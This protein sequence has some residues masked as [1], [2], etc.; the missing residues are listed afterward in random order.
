MIEWLRQRQEIQKKGEGKMRRAVITGLGAV[1]TLG[2][3]RETIAESLRAG[4][5]CITFCPEFEEH[6]FRS[7]VAGW[8]REWNP[9]DHL[10]RKALKFMGR[11]ATFSSTAA[12]SALADSG[13][14]EKDVQSERC[15]VIVGCG[16]SWFFSK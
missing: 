16:W 9:G 3:D 15:G 4:G 12:L 5:S 2:L 1:S 13:L 11:A 14:E 6:G 8:I 7:M 10:P